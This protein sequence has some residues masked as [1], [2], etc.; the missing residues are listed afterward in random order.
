MNGIILTAG[1]IG[2]VSFNGLSLADLGLITVWILILGLYVGAHLLLR[3]WKSGSALRG[4]SNRV[5]SFQ[6]RI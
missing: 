4:T 6:G 5:A 3:P 2:S 1:W